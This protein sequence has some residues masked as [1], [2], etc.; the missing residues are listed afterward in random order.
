VATGCIADASASSCGSPQSRWRSTSNVEEI[1]T[2][3]RQLYLG[4]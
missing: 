2:G 1:G 4:N 3:P